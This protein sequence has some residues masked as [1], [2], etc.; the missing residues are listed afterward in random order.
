MKT[1]P[2]H[3]KHLGRHGAT[4]SL[5]T[6]YSTTAGAIVAAYSNFEVVINVAPFSS[7]L[8]VHS[9]EARQVHHC[10][11]FMSVVVLFI[12]LWRTRSGI[13]YPSYSTYYQ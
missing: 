10:L 6:E 4:V 8:V 12:G 7:E 1:I 3:T 13:T 2:T 11:M 5:G 9:L